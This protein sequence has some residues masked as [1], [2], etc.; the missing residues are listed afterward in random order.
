MEKILEYS[1]E[2]IAKVAG[3][4]ESG[5]NTAQNVSSALNGTAL[6]QLMPT[7][8]IKELQCVVDYFDADLGSSQ[9]ANLK[10]IV[11][12]AAVLAKH[13]NVLA[14][15][16][17]PDQPVAIAAAVDEGLNQAKVAY[18]VGQGV[19][20][21]DAA[22]DTLVDYGAARI[23]ASIDMALPAIKAGAE[24]A[25]ELVTPKVINA[26]CT[27]VEVYPP[28]RYVT[29]FIRACAPYCTE[30][31]KT[32]VAKGIEKVTPYVKKAV[33]VAATK[34]KTVGHNVTHWL[35]EKTKKL[36]S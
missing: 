25:V 7:E 15:V 18:K 5:I 24:K 21:V 11:A 34:V 8:T 33:E 28:A 3:K 17:L 31:V 6:E 12:A 10:K 13:N 23:C 27:A 20:D 29:P 1:Q 9:D 36:L 22:I 30:K 35:K 26:I 19:L 2:C 16:V 4:L 32:A 14:D